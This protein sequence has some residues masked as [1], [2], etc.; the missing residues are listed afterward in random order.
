MSQ[1]LQRVCYIIDLDETLNWG[2]LWE[3]VFFL[4]IGEPSGSTRSENIAW[5]ARTGLGDPLHA[6]SSLWISGME[7]PCHSGLSLLSR[8]TFSLPSGMLILKSAGYAILTQGEKRQK[9]VLE[10]TIYSAPGTRG[11]AFQRQWKSRVR[12]SDWYGSRLRREVGHRGVAE[13]Q[14]TCDSFPLPP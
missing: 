1:E 4:P 10:D 5:C 9:Q 14:L 6:C 13:N 8:P 2:M 12:N 11:R 7:S 3:S